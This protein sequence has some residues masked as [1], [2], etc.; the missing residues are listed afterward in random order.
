[1]TTFGDLSKSRSNHFDLL[2]L[3]LAMAVLYSHS[4]DLTGRQDDGFATL[5]HHQAV[6]STIALSGFFVISGFLVSGSWTHS[7]SPGDFTIRRARRIVP[8][9]VVGVLF[10]FL[11]V[12]PLGADSVSTYFH[13]STAWRFLGFLCLRVPEAVRSAFATNPRPGNLDGSLWTIRLE[14]FCYVIV[15]TAGTIGLLRKPVGLARIA[16]GRCQRSFSNGFHT[17]SIRA[18]A[19]FSHG[20]SF[21]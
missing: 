10:C 17:R 2:R 9:F 11:I 7:K 16:R 21:R 20:V 4:F 19:R 8:G 6:A 14:L 3:V 12:G 1:M 18:T 5:T 15:G 13:D